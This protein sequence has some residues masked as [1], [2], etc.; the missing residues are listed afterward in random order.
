MP[1]DL[2]QQIQDNRPLPDADV[3]TIPPELFDL[4]PDCRLANFLQLE[5]A[6]KRAAGAEAGLAGL[7]AADP[8]THRYV[9]L[10]EA[11]NGASFSAIAAVRRDLGVRDQVRAALEPATTPALIGTPADLGKDR[12]L[13]FSLASA[14][15]LAA[16]P[17]VRFA[18]HW[19]REVSVGHLEG[20]LGE[21]VDSGMDA[22]VHA[23]LSRN[24]LAAVSLDEQD[25][26]RLQVFKRT[27]GGFDA[28]ATLNVAA[29]GQ[30]ALP[31]DGT[32]LGKAILDAGG[33]LPVKFAP[34]T[35]ETVSA[36]VRSVYEKVLPA[37]ERKY[38]AALSWRY[39]TASHGETLVDG[40]FD[41]SPEGLAAYRAALGG[42][43]DRLAGAPGAHICLRKAALT[44][45]LE[46]QNTV[47][48]HLPFLDR[49]QWTSRWDA[50]AKAEVETSEEGR[51]IT[52]TAKASD[53]LLQR[54]SCQSTMALAASLV[55]PKNTVNFDLGYTDNRT[56]EA[57]RLA[58]AMMPLL[59]AYEF[60]EEVGRWLEAAAVAGGAIET[61]M[62]LKVPGEVVAAWLRAPRERDPEFF[63]VFSKV[64]VAVQTAMR[65]WLPFVYFQNLDRYEE[66]AAAYPLVFYKTTRAFAGHPRCEFA[67][68]LVTPESPGVARSW[69]VRAL[70]PELAAIEK[71]LKASG[72]GMPARSYAAWKAPQILGEIVRKPKLLNALLM[73]D[74]F[75]IDRLVHLGLHARTLGDQAAADP[76][77]A[78]RDLMSLASDF[79]ATFH[80]RLRRLYGGQ[81][82][83]GFGSL[84]LM[85]ATRALG[86]ALDGNTAISG[87]FWASAGGREQ[88]FVNAGYRSK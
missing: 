29:T 78:T 2:I 5:T 48:L 12:A 40:S 87:T 35:L 25:R 60:P 18:F 34:G 16:T 36:L 73:G 9:V 24:F 52:Y 58:R 17:R 69:A 77:R 54:S 79:T 6:L 20:G 15:K 85:E 61:R 71:E 82:F 13:V 11:N 75:F 74:G 57:T 83:V 22:A 86:A 10:T 44:E 33:G 43:F 23:S 21:D 41:F 84:L 59:E 1:D 46:G 50:L 14:V 62:T 37:L 49:K 32:P 26:L 45:A 42:N 27:D 70:V 39:A 53:R 31:P 3:E 55:F 4:P 80:R 72:R 76:F 51:L 56:G 8:A 65:K 64:S 67:Y 19:L 68:D 30:S 28:A 88:T 47:E 66:V 38:A 81:D 63:D 7:L